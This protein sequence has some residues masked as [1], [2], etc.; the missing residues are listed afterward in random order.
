MKKLVIAIL[1]AMC[2]STATA[3]TWYGF[4]TAGSDDAAFF[5]DFESATRQADSATLWV[6]YVNREDKPDQ[7]GSY[8]TATKYT[9]FC[10]NRTYQAATQVTYDKNHNHMKTYSAP[11][12][13]ADIVPGTVSESIYKAVCA[14]DFP[15]KKS[16]Y[17]V[18]VGDN[19]IFAAAKRLLD[20]RNDPAP[21]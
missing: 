1:G 5:F 9:Y 12:K 20:G 6:K 16:N 18:P 21:K 17:Y 10:K 13:I 8:A 3:A 11:G 15:S 14:P 2:A 19:D 7:D 4:T